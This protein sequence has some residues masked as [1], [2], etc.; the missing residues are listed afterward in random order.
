MNACPEKL[1]FSSFS[2]APNLSFLMPLRVTVSTPCDGN[3][4]L[5]TVLLPS[6]PGA[7]LVSSLVSIFPVSLGVAPRPRV[8]RASLVVAPGDGSHIR[9]PPWWFSPAGA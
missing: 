7:L 8:P 1:I 6:A 4:L 9:K 3:A 2:Y 5:A